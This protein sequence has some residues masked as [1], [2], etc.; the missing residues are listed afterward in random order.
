MLRTH[1]PVSYQSYNAD[2]L[3]FE[4]PLRSRSAPT[5]QKTQANLSISLLHHISPVKRRA[6]PRAPPLPS[7][8]IPSHHTTPHP[9]AST[10]ASTSP[11]PIPRC[12]LP[13]ASYPH[14]RIPY[15]QFPPPRIGSRCCK[16]SGYVNAH[17]LPLLHSRLARSPRKPGQFSPLTW[18]T[19][20]RSLR[21]GVGQGC[22]QAGS[23][24]VVFEW[25]YEGPR[26]AV[27]AL[28]RRCL[29]AGE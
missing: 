1:F 9:P 19:V 6:S 20:C 23:G 25:A 24:V 12:P 14:A 16:R 27:A 7:Y 22:N 11:S 18:S 29:W 28:V 15:P 21:V 26:V 5:P 3:N 8:P 10:V 13:D 4:T 17:S 2:L